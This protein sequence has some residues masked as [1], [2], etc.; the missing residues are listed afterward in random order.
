M[1]NRRVLSTILSLFALL[2]VSGTVLQAQI[3]VRISLSPRWVQPSVLTSRLN[4]AN[5]QATFPNYNGNSVYNPMAGDDEVNY[6]DIEFWISTNVKFWAAQ[7]DCTVPP[8][9]YKFFTPD[10]SADDP[11]DSNVLTAGDVW[12]NPLIPSLTTTSTTGRFIQTITQR[13]DFSAMI[14]EV[15]VDTRLLLSTVRL[16]V[17]PQVVAPANTNSTTFVGSGTL[18]CTLGLFDRDGRSVGTSTYAPPTPQVVTAGYTIRGN[19]TLQGQTNHANSSV[20]CTS[21]SFIIS[22][23][24]QTDAAGNWSITGLREQGTYICT[25]W[26][27]RVDTAVNF[28]I[29]PFLAKTTPVNLMG[30]D[31]R[32]LPNVLRAG[33][34]NRSDTFIN[35]LDLSFITANFNTTGLPYSLGDVTGEGTTDRTDLI[36]ASGN[37]S[38]GEANLSEHYV[39]SGQYGPSNI[40]Y[41]HRILINNNEISQDSTTL[42][43]FLP[44]TNQDYWAAVSPDGTRVAFTRAIGVGAARRYVLHVAPITGINIGTPVRITPPTG[45]N[46]N[47]FAPSWSSDGTQLAFVCTNTDPAIFSLNRGSLCVTEANGRNLRVLSSAGNIKIFPPAW[48]RSTTIFFG[49][50]S[51]GLTNCVDRICSLKLDDNSLDTYSTLTIYADMPSIPYGTDFLYYRYDSD[52]NLANGNQIRFANVDRDGD[53]IPFVAVF[54]NSPALGVLATTYYHR[55]VISLGAGVSINYL[56]VRDGFRGVYIATVENA[57]LVISQ[58]NG[59][60]NNYLNGTAIPSWSFGVSTTLDIN[61]NPSNNDI[62]AFRL[63][64]DWT[65]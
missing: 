48:L 47:D 5:T 51:N 37:F 21:P 54:D 6:T 22:S 4:V 52:T 49:G 9:I 27:N 31:A 53:G 1:K 38:I 14:G 25:Q 23:L 60:G 34:T 10:A 45:W 7:I 36:L 29:E 33:N 17:R 40:L 41:D 24:T 11:N 13:G 57:G 63:T 64:V 20:E 28:A 15:G 2:L 3:P 39:V 65:P 43:Q 12:D 58:I 44:G 42:R 16:Q 32:M 26:A 35:S 30:T 8:T 50:A 56:G 61:E 18:T 62:H 55:V 46:Y 19:T 59:N